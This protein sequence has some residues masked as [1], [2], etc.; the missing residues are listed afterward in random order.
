MAV[1]HSKFEAYLDA[2]TQFKKAK[3]MGNMHTGGA[4]SK[5]EKKRK[6]WMEEL[7][8]EARAEVGRK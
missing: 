2:L 6:E 1:D 5:Y 8:K 4:R 3:L 7:G